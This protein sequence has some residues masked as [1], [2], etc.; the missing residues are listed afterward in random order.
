MFQSYPKESVKLAE[1]TRTAHFEWHV[2]RCF[3]QGGFDG[4]LLA[5]GAA[6]PAARASAAT[7]MIPLVQQC[8]LVTQQSN[9]DLLLR[10]YGAQS[11]SV[12]IAFL[13]DRRCVPDK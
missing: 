6:T 10:R 9:D 8:L 2:F 5:D 13:A 12:M 11:L 3:V 1:L 4:L 7:G